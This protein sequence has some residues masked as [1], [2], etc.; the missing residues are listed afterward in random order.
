MSC[1]TNV[2]LAKTRP[3][4]KTSGR[5]LCSLTKSNLLNHLGVYNFLQ[6]G[7]EVLQAHSAQI[8]AGAGTDGDR[9]VFH[10]PVTHNDHI[11]HLLQSGLTDLLAD[12]LVAVIHLHAEA[13]AV[14]CVRQILGIIQ[15][16]VG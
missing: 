5:V 12:L 15:R 3:A 4:R 13:L 14:Q 11:G 9:L 10:I 8:L 6:L 2:R 7:G 16:T 1:K